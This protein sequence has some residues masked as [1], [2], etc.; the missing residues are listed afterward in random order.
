MVPHQVY[1]VHITTAWWWQWLYVP[2][3]VGL[4][5]MGM[6]PNWEKVQRAAALALRVRLELVD[7]RALES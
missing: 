4:A 3:V 2:G 5:A 7:N 6:T 1:R